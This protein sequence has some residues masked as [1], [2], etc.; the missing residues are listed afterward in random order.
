[1]TLHEIL[2]DLRSERVKKVILDCDAYN[3]I[4]DQYA[5]AFGVGSPKMNVL[6]VNAV[7]F[8]NYRCSGFEDG[9]KRSYDE[10]VKVLKFIGAENETKAYLGCPT[11]LSQMPE[12]TPVDSPAVQN[13][14]KTVHESDEIVY[15]IAT[16]AATNVAS[17]IMT[18]PTIK[19]NLCVLWV[20]LNTFEG[21]GGPA[22]EF[23]YAQDE[24]AGRY[25]VDCGVNL[26][27]LPAMG[28]EGLGTQTL[29]GDQAFLDSVV[30]GD[31]EQAKFFRNDLPELAYPGETGWTHHFWDVAGPG[32]VHDASA[33]DLSV[34]MCP[35]IRGDGVWA[36]D[37]ERHD[38]IYMSRLN[39]DKVMK[40]TFDAIS[41]LI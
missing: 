16:G 41:K 30:I 29:I 39:P 14:I 3:D 6:S 19:D 38:V 22:G 25:L 2:A 26:V 17:A 36:F 12:N 32:L 9:M 1:M 37:T 5:I 11:P 40:D 20:G 28:P 10:I 23:N 24:V 7:L 34:R 27:I 35:R 33:F 15:I 21:G 8:N 13:I 4:D 31:S 18:D